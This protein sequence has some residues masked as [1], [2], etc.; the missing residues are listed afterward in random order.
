MRKS[1]STHQT[2]GLML[3]LCFFFQAEDGIRDYKV[4]G[5][6]TC[7]LPIY[8]KQRQT[9]YGLRRQ[10]LEGVEQKQRVMDMMQGIVEEYIDRH[11]AND[12][13]P[14]TWDLA[15]LRNEILTQFGSKINLKQLA[16]LHR[17]EMME[18]I[19]DQLQGKYQ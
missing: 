3:F 1:Q 13:H 16:S 17:Q 9:V 10:L 2:D 14:D 18:A 19:F 11:C 15:T 12:K 4:T 5:V 6:Q 8:N 7:A